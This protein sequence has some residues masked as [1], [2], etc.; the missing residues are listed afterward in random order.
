LVPTAP[1][2]HF[3]ALPDRPGDVVRAANL[4]ATRTRIDWS[5]RVDLEAGL[6]ATM[7]WAR[8]LNTDEIR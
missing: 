3:G 7:T 6:A 4:E 1:A 5:P 2:P 8:T